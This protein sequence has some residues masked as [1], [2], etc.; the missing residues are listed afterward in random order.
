MSTRFLPYSDM[1]L[2]FPRN[3]PAF[4]SLPRFLLTAPIANK[5]S[6]RFVP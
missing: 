4:S 1:Y 5:A 3:V 2:I 6:V